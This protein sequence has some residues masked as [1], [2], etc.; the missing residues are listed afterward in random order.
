[1]DQV[2]VQ[3]H[4]QAAWSEFP[5]WEK[6]KDKG[7]KQVLARK[8]KRDECRVPSMVRGIERISWEG[9]S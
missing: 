4:S 2:Q 3:L 7:T 1:M 5:V 8:E 6:A 9:Q